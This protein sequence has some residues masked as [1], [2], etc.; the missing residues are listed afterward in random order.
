[1]RDK[2][3][4]K[5]F[6]MIFAIVIVSCLSSNVCLAQDETKS[7]QAEELIK[8]RPVT[9]TV[10]SSKKS[11]S[12]KNSS[13]KTRKNISRKKRFYRVVRTS[14]IKTAVK[15]SQ[16]LPKDSEDALL[17]LTVWKIRPA[18]KNDA[19]K[20]LIEEEQGGKTQ[21]AEYTLERMESDTTVSE[22]EKLRISVESLSHSGYLYVIDRELYSDGSYSAPKLIYPTLRSQNRNNPI[23]AGNLVFIPE[24]PRYFRVK[25]NQAEK[26][27]VAEVLTL[28]V[29]P[30]ILI[31]QTILQTKAI[32]LPFEQ[33]AG[34]LKQWEVGTALLEEIDGAGQTI[35]I[36]EQSA[37]QNTAKGLNEES[38]SLMQDDPTPQSVFRARIKRGN[39]I[40]VNVNLRF[41]T[42]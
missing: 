11:V 12:E 1:M 10:S 23:G 39:P 13:V 5:T 34:W 35:T 40:L 38:G 15:S 24:A 26:K 27:Q 4:S 30:R 8:K 9:K 42:D 22:G 21:N 28:I 2:K 19:A 37:G 36:A 3:T 20:E 41:R 31:D 16:V 17:G 25:S 7:I 32:E 18:T 14:P 29:S 6:F 33:F